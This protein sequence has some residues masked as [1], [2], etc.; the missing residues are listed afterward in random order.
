MQDASVSLLLHDKRRGCGMLNR[1]LG[2]GSRNRVGRRSQREV[3]ASATTQ[4]SNRQQR[5]K[6]QQ[7]HHQHAWHLAPMPA[8]RTQTKQSKHSKS[9]RSAPSRHRRSRRNPVRRTQRAACRDTERNGRRTASRSDRRRREGVSRTLRQAIDIQRQIAH[10]GRRTHR[11]H[12]ERKAGR[13]TG[14]DVLRLRTG[15]RIREVLHD[16]RDRCRCAGPEAGITRIRRRDRVR[17][18]RQRARR[19][20]RIT[21]QHERD[22]RAIRT[23]RSRPKHRRPIQ[24][25]DRPG[26]SR[27]SRSHRSRER[28]RG[29]Q[30]LRRL[31][32][33]QR[34]RRHRLAHNLSQRSGRRC[35]IAV[36]PAI[37]GSD[38][39]RSGRQAGGAECRDTGSTHS[40]RSKYRRTVK[41]G[42]RATGARRK[43]RRKRN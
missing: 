19:I 9:N 22:H 21:R 27:H 8:D 6:E 15:H 30:Q 11:S 20:V 23:Q 34:D 5:A 3:T 37:G 41:E 26:R 39:V 16:V 24:E 43:R 29:A 32:L 38:R 40:T 10:E 17:S 42:H 4:R 7:K 18:R 12:A 28:H 35:R 25:R 33:R 36:I 2:A 31:A 13:I 14:E 1:P